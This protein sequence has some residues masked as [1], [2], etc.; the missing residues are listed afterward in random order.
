METQTKLGMNRTGIDMSPLA[1]RKMLKA[2]D[3]TGDTQGPL[4]SPPVSPIRQEYLAQ[5]AE[6]G[7]VP[8]PGSLKGVASTAKEAVTGHRPQVLIDK[9]GE[10]LAFERSGVRLYEALLTKLAAHADLI[11]QATLDR[12]TQFKDEEVQ[13][14]QMVRE[15]MLS[16][17]A[18]PTAMTPC[19]DVAGVEGMGLVKVVSDPRSNAL[20]SLHAILSAELIDGDGWGMLVALARN[21]KHDKMAERFEQALAQENE[22]LSFV[23]ELLNKLCLAE[24]MREQPGKMTH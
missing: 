9:L 7:S 19:A 5:P 12:L 20:Q 8:L 1:V 22:H 14:F 4:N 3:V 24:A 17:G 10:R 2:D 6:L 23:R 16:I 18:D 11:D 15:A 21:L 13:H